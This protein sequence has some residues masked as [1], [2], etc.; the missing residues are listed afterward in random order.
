M[1]YK[2]VRRFK[3]NNHK[4]HIYNVGDEYPTKGQKSTKVRITELATGDNSYKQIY[5][6]EVKR[7]ETPAKSKE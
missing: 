5:I 4:G 1:N 7:D 2:V 3:E 6:E